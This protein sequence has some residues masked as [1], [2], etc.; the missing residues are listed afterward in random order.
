MH[1]WLDFNPIVVSIKHHFFQYIYFRVCMLC[2]HTCVWSIDNVFLPSLLVMVPIGSNE[3]DLF[4]F[5]RRLGA[6]DTRTH[7]ERTHVGIESV[8]LTH[9]R[10]ENLHAQEMITHTNEEI[11]T[12]TWEKWGRFP[13]NWATPCCRLKSKLLT[14]QGIQRIIG[15]HREVLRH[16]FYLLLTTVDHGF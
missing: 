3:K 2:I 4:F 9:A 8:R 16:V 12:Y 6:W 14:I 11:A 13:T 5:L 1:H 7:K 10:R 15:L